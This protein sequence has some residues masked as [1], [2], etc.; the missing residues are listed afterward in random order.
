MKLGVS[1]TA[2][3]SS[4]WISAQVHA[5]GC[6]RPGA[7]RAYSSQGGSTSATS[8]RVPSASAPSRSCFRSACRRRGSRVGVGL[9]LCQR[10]PYGRRRVTLW[11]APPGAQRSPSGRERQ[12]SAAARLQMQH[13]RLP[14]QMR[15]LQGRQAACRAAASAAKEAASMRGC[16]SPGSNPGVRARRAPSGRTAASRAGPPAG[17]SAAPARASWG[18]RRSG[19]SARRPAHVLK[20]VTPRAARLAQEGCRSAVVHMEMAQGN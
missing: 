5:S 11:R 14:R 8:K 1:I 16:D 3:S 13:A 4:A 12:W 19:R 20:D 17:P 6:A 15:L 7:R 10:L 18:T 9:G 2:S